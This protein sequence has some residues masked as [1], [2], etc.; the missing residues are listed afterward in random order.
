MD[1]GNAMEIADELKQAYKTFL[2]PSEVWP[3]NTYQHNLIMTYNP[4]SVLEFGCGTGKNL[5]LFDKAITTMGI[6]ISQPAVAVAQLKGVCAVWD[7]ETRLKYMDSKFDV[8]F[9]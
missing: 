4:E 9:T 2:A 6:D 1:R 5:L 7:D 8:V 3:V